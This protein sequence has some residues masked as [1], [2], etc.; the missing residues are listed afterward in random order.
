MK[1]LALL[2]TH[3]W[4]QQ[5]KILQCIS[6]KYIF[7]RYDV[8]YIFIQKWISKKGYEICIETYIWDHMF[9]KEQKKPSEISLL[10]L[11]SLEELKR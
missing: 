3:L 11:Q 1:Q 7:Y 4:K 10:S 6:Y 2:A 9:Q 8:V 5:N